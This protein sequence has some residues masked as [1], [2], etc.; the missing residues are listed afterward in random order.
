MALFELILS[1][2][3]P[4]YLL[5]FNVYKSLFDILG[6]RGSMLKY[7]KKPEKVSD[8]KNDVRKRT[9]IWYEIDEGIYTMYEKW[10]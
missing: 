7:M 3:Q 2:V 4:G 5:F 9:R 6:T 10:Y 1:F 8:K